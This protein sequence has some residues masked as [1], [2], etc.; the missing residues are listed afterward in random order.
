[1][2]LLTSTSVRRARVDDGRNE[3]T[4]SQTPRSGAQPQARAVD[5]EAFYSPPFLLLSKDMRS[6]QG[7]PTHTSHETH[8]YACKPPA[9][10]HHV[11][12]RT[13]APTALKGFGSAS[14][15]FDKIRSE[16]CVAIFTESNRKKMWV[17]NNQYWEKVGTEQ[18]KFMDRARNSSPAAGPLVSKGQRQ[19]E[20]ARVLTP[21][22]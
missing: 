21:A 10:G 22:R 7:N 17:V 5:L 19:E 11:R 20:H 1:M 13:H 2:H 6:C 16:M 14:C 9:S 3:S 4:R 15:E 8:A 12:T 18:V